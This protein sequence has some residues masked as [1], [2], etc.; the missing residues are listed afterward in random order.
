MITS[1][2]SDCMELLAKSY[3]APG[4][5][6]VVEAPTYLGGLMAF[7]GY[8]ADVRGVPLDDAGMRVDVL[9]GLLAGGLRPKIVYP[10]PASQTPPGLSMSADP[11]QALVDLA[12]RY[13]FLIL[14]D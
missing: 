10:L 13:D 5:V 8:E 9:A 12:R 11:R 2:G 3:L 7:R 14:E 4:D 1:G 6:V